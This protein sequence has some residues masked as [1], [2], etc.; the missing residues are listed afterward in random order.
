M[1]KQDDYDVIF[2]YTRAQAIADGVL[3]DVTD[4]ANGAGFKI[5]VAL[6]SRVWAEY[7]AVPDGVECQDETGRLWDI[8]SFSVTWRKCSTPSVSRCPTQAPT[9]AETRQ[10]VRKK[11][12]IS[13]RSR[14]PCRVSEGIASKSAIACFWVRDGV[15]FFWTPGALTAAMSWAVSHKTRPLEASW[16]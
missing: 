4:T 14:M 16:W 13:A 1:N 8:L 9:T 7:V 15:A 5:P 12:L 3:V 2:A 11:T 10:S 6:T